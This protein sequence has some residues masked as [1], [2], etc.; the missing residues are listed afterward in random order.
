MDTLLVYVNIVS[1]KFHILYNPQVF[2]NRFIF[3]ESV[4]KYMW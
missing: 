2:H 3:Q 1:P 4:N